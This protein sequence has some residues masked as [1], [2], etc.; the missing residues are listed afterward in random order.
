MLG[1]S[2]RRRRAPRK[3]VAPGSRRWRP[4]LIGLPLA[5]IAPFAIGYLV[6]VFVM[7]PPRE[8]SAAGV[9]VPDLRGSTE[10]DARRELRS[11]G[12]A[13]LDVTELPHPEAP[14]GQVIAQSPLPG[15]QLRPGA[16]VRVALSTGRPR[17]LV[18]DVIGFTADRAQSM[19]TRSGFT[20]AF[21]TQESTAPAGRV[22]RSEPQPG[23]ERELPFEV[24]LIVS[25]GVPPAPPPDTAA[26]DTLQRHSPL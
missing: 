16:G 14:A 9:A 11:A 23:S 7:F 13:L 24:T 20:V 21:I 25:S 10:A 3:E 12:L 18:P 1:D 2:L 22:L 4:L 6:A 19:L 15:Q 8:V 17:G 5:L 26:V